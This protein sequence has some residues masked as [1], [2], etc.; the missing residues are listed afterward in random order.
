M[1]RGGGRVK[2]QRNPVLPVVLLIGG[3]PANI[4][5]LSFFGSDWRLLGE[6]VIT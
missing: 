1:G 4:V 2:L 5:M 6:L 3:N